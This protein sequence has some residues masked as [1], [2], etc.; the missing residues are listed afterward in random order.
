MNSGVAFAHICA[1]YV[2]IED[3]TFCRDLMLAH[4]EAS[5]T[6]KLYLK[7]RWLKEASGVSRSHSDLSYSGLRPDAK[8]GVLTYTEYIVDWKA[9][10]D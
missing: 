6:W 2:P 9:A 5:R 3:K 1:V 8:C 4:C 7:E 10:T